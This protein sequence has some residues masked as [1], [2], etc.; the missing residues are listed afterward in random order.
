M[1]FF[2]VIRNSGGLLSIW[3]SYKGISIPSFSD[4]GFLG[5][6][7]KWGASKTLCFIFN[8]YLYA[9]WLI[10]LSNGMICV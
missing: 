6:C 8:V 9:F 7:V 3:C 10:K 2:P 4:S 1:D 5:V